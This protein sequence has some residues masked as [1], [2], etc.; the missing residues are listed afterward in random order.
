M[1]D[2][3][4]SPFPF[5]SFMTCFS[6]NF[7]FYTSIEMQFSKTKHYFINKSMKINKNRLFITKC[8]RIVT[9]SSDHSIR[10]TS[11]HNW[12]DCAFSFPE[13]KQIS[14]SIDRNVFNGKSNELLNWFLNSWR[15]SQILC[16]WMKRNSKY[17]VLRIADKRR[18]I[19]KKIKGKEWLL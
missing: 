19:G 2:S 17:S 14:V 5:P 15:K 16:I 10:R 4:D 3:I 18:N 7:S 11:N 1:N 9:Q 12:K 8:M 13:P 6:R